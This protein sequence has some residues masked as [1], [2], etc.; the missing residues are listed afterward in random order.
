[1][2]KRMRRWICSLIAVTPFV[3]AALAFAG[4]A[5][6]QTGSPPRPGETPIF[7]WIEGTYIGSSVRESNWLFPV[8][9]SMH[10][11][12]IVALAGASTLLD[13]RLLNR[14]FLKEQPTSQVASRLLPVMWTSFGVMAITGTL[15]F[16][17]EAWQCYTSMSFRIKLALLLAVG[18][19]AL[20]FHLGSYRTI[21]TWEQAP[22]A[23]GAARAA[24]WLSMTLWVCIVFAGRWIAYW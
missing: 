10:V 24:A 16:V 18:L 21:K 6:G 8:I 17:S 20:V 5:F 4:A 11:L 23:P 7:K 9:E 13:L 15:M 3:I 22:V 2:R 14:G 12:G 19:N 1:M